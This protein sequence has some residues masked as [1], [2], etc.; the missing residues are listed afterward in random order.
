MKNYVGNC[1]LEQLP[2]IVNISKGFS[3]SQYFCIYFTFGCWEVLYRFSIEER[4]VKSRRICVGRTSPSNKHGADSA[5]E[6][7]GNK[8]E[9]ARARRWKFAAEVGVPTRVRGSGRGNSPL[10]VRDKQRCEKR[11]WQKKTT[12]R[13]RRR[14]TDLTHEKSFPHVYLFLSISSR[15]F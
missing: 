4:V 15:Y 13:K 9:R 7:E 10:P 1:S 6:T 8:A 11:E 3:L 12:I 5:K 14:P 2:E